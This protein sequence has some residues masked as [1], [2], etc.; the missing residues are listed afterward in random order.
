MLTRTLAE[1][2]RLLPKPVPKK[3]KPIL[4]TYKA[5]HEHC[6]KKLTQP[7]KTTADRTASQKP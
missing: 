2:G 6:K 3:D 7:I 4:K 1:K 5:N